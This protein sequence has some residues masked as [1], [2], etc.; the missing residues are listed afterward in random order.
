MKQ[1]NLDTCNGDK[2]HEGLDGFIVS[3]SEPAVVFEFVDGVFSE[4]SGCIKELVVSGGSLT[5]GLGRDDGGACLLHD[6]FTYGVAVVS[7]V[8]DDRLGPFH[9]LPEPECNRLA[10]H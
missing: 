2:G 9:A 6:T 4:V 3:R 5:V 7:L 8:G 1:I 10:R